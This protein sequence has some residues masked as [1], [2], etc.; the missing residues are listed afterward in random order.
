METLQGSRSS[1]MSGDGTGP[2]AGVEAK[3]DFD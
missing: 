3:A 1:L 2:P